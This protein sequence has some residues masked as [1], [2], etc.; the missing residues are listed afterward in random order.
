MLNP[1]CQRQIRQ[2]EARSSCFTDTSN[3]GLACIQGITRTINKQTSTRLAI[4]VQRQVLAGYQACI[5]LKL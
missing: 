3:I 5:S 4:P 2:V 1:A